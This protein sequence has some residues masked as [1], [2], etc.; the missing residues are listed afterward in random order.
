MSPEQARGLRNIDHRTDLWS[1]GVIAYKCVTGALPFEGESVGDL[2]VKICT[3]PVPSPS[4]AAPRLP[5]AFDSWFFRSMERDP[6]KRFSQA[7]ELS[8]ALS[9]AAGLSARRTGSSQEE[10]TF[11]RPQEGAGPSGSEDLAPAGITSSPFTASPRPPRPPRRALFIVLSCSARRRGDR[12]RRRHQ[13]GGSLRVV[14]HDGWSRLCNCLRCHPLCPRRRLFSRRCLRPPRPCRSQFRARH[15]GRRD[16]RLRRQLRPLKARVLPTQPTH[17]QQ[18]LRRHPAP[19]RH[20]RARSG[21]AH[22]RQADPHQLRQRVPSPRRRKPIRGTDHGRLP[23]RSPALLI[24]LGVAAVTWGAV[25]SAQVNDGE[26]AA[27]RELFKEGDE[28]Q[29][30][31]HFAEALDKFQRAEQIFAAPTNELRIAECEAALGQLLESGEAYRS[32][33]RTPLPPGSLPLRFRR[34]STRRKPN[35]NKSSRGF[36]SSSSKCNPSSR[37]CACKWMARASRQRSS[38]NQCLSTRVRTRCPSRRR[39]TQAPSNL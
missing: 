33:S 3:G 17:W 22:R 7:S 35:S 4:A 37:T 36:R 30:A 10:A 18:A 23:M 16:C 28:L 24:S 29:R 34:R 19:Q 39:D 31:G 12:S 5:K 27:A 21:G 6:S 11:G 32:V 20:N 15:R 38:D 25:A 13:D 26:R 1:L 2:L 8:S 9:L 14:R